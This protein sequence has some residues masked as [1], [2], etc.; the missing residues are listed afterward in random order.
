MKNKTFILIFR[1]TYGTLKLGKKLDY[2]YFNVYKESILK[3][4]NK[5]YSFYRSTSDCTDEKWICE[6]L[7]NQTKKEYKRKNWKKNDELELII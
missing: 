2:E 6:N 7:L 4:C 3:Y 1:A 5:H